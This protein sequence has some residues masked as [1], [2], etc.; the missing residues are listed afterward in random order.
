ME[1]L[2]A[3]LDIHGGG[4]DLI[5]PHHENEIAQS[6]AANGVKFV[7]FWV[8]AGLLE[9]EGQK[10]SKSLG[11]VY[12]LEDLQ[13]RGFTPSAFRYLT[14]MAHYRS[15]LNFTWEGLEAAQNGLR[16]LRELAAELSATDST[17]AS[18]PMVGC[19]EYEQRFL[20]AVNN[21]L[22]MPQA[23]AITW[24]LV[25]RKDYPEP[26][27]LKSLLEFDKVLGLKLDRARTET[28]PQVIKQ[29]VE[30]RE[31]FRRKGNYAAAD[32]IR[33][34]ILNQCYTVEDTP[35]GPRV[36]KVG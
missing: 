36:R 27:R 11:N 14:L 22:D 7:R 30:E 25:R 34:K 17:A 24:E 35:A 9:V 31:Q 2:G 12:S 18:S 23:L 15:K 10:M 5:F 29:L 20:E 6:E 3:T 16:R 28:I 33:Q 21:D 13:D 1:Y 32:Q 8:H 26:A 19:A 4:Q